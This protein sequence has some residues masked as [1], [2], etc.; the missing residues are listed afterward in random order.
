MFVSTTV[1]MCP[2]QFTAN[3]AAVTGH[4]ERLGNLLVDACH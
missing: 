4:K 1:D 2:G 3:L